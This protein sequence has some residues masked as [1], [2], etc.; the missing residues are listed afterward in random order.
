MQAASRFLLF[1][2]LF[3]AALSWNSSGAR[4]QGT[5]I[6]APPNPVWTTTSQPDPKNAPTPDEACRIQH[7]TYNPGAP[8]FPPI[9]VTDNL[10]SC[11]WLAA[12]WPGGAGNTI[13]PATVN[14]VCASGFKMRNGLCFDPKAENADC[15]CPNN[16]GAPL[17]P[18]APLAGDP[19]NVLSGHQIETETDYA[20]A[21]GRLEV[22]RRYSSNRRQ[23]I[24]EGQFGFGSSWQGLI[25]GRLYLA[26]INADTAEY[27][28]GNGSGA[29]AFYVPDPSNLNSWAYAP[30]SM[31]SLRLTMEAPPAVDRPAFLAGAAVVNG[32]AEFRL[33]KDNGDHILFCRAGNRPGAIRRSR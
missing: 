13:L 9:R 32:P 1:C 8:Y 2:G 19:I 18:A 27:D 6:A 30:L 17:A 14:G 25:P 29:N 10:Y 24:S 20:T 5:P 12:Q 33:S 26:G 22:S 7:A 3:L 4:A 11:Q 15:D 23:L 21:D 28:K 31:T 16:D